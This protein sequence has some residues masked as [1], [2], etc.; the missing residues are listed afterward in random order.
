MPRTL[1]EIGDKLGL[2]RERIRQIEVKALEKLKRINTVFIPEFIHLA[3]VYEGRLVIDDTNHPKYGLKNYTR[4]IKNLKTSG[5]ENGFK[6]LL[7]LVE[8]EQEVE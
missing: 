6:L 8:K 2:T 5:Y 1:E 7:F 4:K 3:K